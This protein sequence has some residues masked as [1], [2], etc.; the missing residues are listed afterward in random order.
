M[1]LFL[2]YSIH[3]ARTMLQHKLWTVAGV[4]AGLLYGVFGHAIIF[5]LL[6]NLHK[7]PASW[8][9]LFTVFTAA[10]VGLPVVADALQPQCRGQQGAVGSSRNKRD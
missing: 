5:V 6:S 2:P 3:T 7:Y 1:L 8:P 9:V 10:V 4:C